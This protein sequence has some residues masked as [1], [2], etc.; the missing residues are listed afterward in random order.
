MK[1][2]EVQRLISFA[3]QQCEHDEWTGYQT[4]GTIHFTCK[5]CSKLVTRKS[6]FIFG[7]GTHIVV[8]GQPPLRGIKMKKSM[9]PSEVISLLFRICRV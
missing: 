7:K 2:S 6:D 1:T 5:G 9:K 4:L 8:E 3:V